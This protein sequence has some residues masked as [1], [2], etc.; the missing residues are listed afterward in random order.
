MRKTPSGRCGICSGSGD[1]RGK[2]PGGYAGHDHEGRQTVV[3]GH[4]PADGKAGNFRIVPFDR[5]CDRRVAQHAEIVGVVRV[6]PDVFSVEDE[7][8][9]KCLLQAG[10]EFIA[11]AG[12]QR[13]KCVRCTEKERIQNRRTAS[14]TGKY[15]VFVERTL[16][17]ARIGYAKNR[18]G[19]L[20][21]VGD[22]DPW[23][24]LAGGSQAVVRVAA[25]TKI[26]GPALPRDGILGVRERALSRPCVR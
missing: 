3:V 9:S 10:V 18:A 20:D 11:E 7:V 14:H 25:K 22:A 1:L 12:R 4:G 16:Q 19:R 15:Q 6:F 26:E 24:G 5:K 21:V 8:L 2:K 13:S 23:F 17:S